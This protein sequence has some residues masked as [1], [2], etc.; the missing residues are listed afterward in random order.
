MKTEGVCLYKK[1]MVSVARQCVFGLRIYNHVWLMQ[2]RKPCK[3]RSGLLP[4]PL[5]LL[6]T[7]SSV[8]H[9]KLLWNWH[10][11]NIENNLMTVVT[12]TLWWL[13]GVAWCIDVGRSTHNRD[14]Q[15]SK[16]TK[17]KCLF[18]VVRHVWPL[19][20]TLWSM[21]MWSCTNYIV[22]TRTIQWKVRTQIK[23]TV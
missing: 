20:I 13:E 10:V 16:N 18:E 21:W 1:C 8:S 5:L 6:I 3:F 17:W 22:R 7:H 11:V 14:L 2:T 23:C 12:T 4:P 19:V 15:T 9:W